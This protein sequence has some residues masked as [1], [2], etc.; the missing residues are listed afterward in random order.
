MTGV[1]RVL[2]TGKV[3]CRVGRGPS[4]ESAWLVSSSNE[5]PMLF[6][7]LRGV[8][9]RLATHVRS[10]QY[11]VLSAASSSAEFAPL[12]L[13]QRV[14]ISSFWLERTRSSFR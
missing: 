1:L 7:V 4:G 5:H 6:R 8:R 13:L 2:Q 14:K 10:S 3:H 9:Q 12:N 11:G